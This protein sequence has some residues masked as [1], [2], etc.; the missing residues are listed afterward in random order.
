MF[1]AANNY[2]DKLFTCP[3]NRSHPLPGVMMT[4]SYVA[5]FYPALALNTFTHLASFTSSYKHFFLRLSAFHV[6]F[7]LR[8]MQKMQLPGAAR[9]EPKPFQLVNDLLHLET[10][11][12]VAEQFLQLLC[13]KTKLFGYI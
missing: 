1:P 3:P 10:L 11:F 12:W 9:L 5:L 8:Q 2:E 13:S 7:V 4:A 6:T